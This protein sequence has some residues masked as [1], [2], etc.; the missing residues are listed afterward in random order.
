VDDI[1]LRPIHHRFEQRVR[2]HVFICMM[3]A[4]LVW[5]LR[6]VFAPLT[7]TDEQPPTPD[8]PVAPAARSTSALSKVARKTT[9]EGSEVRGFRELLD[10]LGGLTRNGDDLRTAGHSHPD[11]A[12]S[13]RTARR[14]GPSQARVART[15]HRHEPFFP[16]GAGL[17]YPE[18]RNFGLVSS[19]APE[20]LK[21]GILSA[22]WKSEDDQLMLRSS[23]LC[24][25]DIQLEPLQVV[26]S[27]TGTKIIAIVRSGIVTGRLRGQ[28]LSGGG[29]WL[30]IDKQRIGHVDVRVIL[31]LDDGTL[32]DLTYRGRLVIPADGWTRLS[33]GEDLM[34]DEAYLRI[35]PE[36]NVTLGRYDWLNRIVAVG[37]GTIGAG[38]VRYR[39]YEIH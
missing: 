11:P 32:V 29:D 10:H 25:L 23:R 30:L 7:F 14:H 2:S 5:H 39:V 12:P 26:R 21:E 16:D 24:D 38:W 8:N 17:T 18:R 31:R 15:I 6:Q 19:Q 13:L 9:H 33:N 34:A 4:Y 28:V 37:V 36:F 3:A 27:S 20:V 35:S 22:G 1:D